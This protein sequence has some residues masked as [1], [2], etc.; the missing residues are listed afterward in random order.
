[1]ECQMERDRKFS[2]ASKTNGRRQPP[3]DVSVGEKTEITKPSEDYLRFIFET[4][5]FCK[6]ITFAPNSLI[7]SLLSE[8]M[9]LL[10]ASSTITDR[11]RIRCD[12]LQAILNFSIF[13]CSFY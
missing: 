7:I 12:A 1:M 10:K 13:A 8:V 9:V 5:F 2:K 3:N 4:I 6:S 11:K